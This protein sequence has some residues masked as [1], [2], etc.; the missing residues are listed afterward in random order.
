[1]D[2]RHFGRRLVTA[3]R[4]FRNCS[5][6]VE[7]SVRSRLH[8]YMNFWVEEFCNLSS[9]LHSICNS[10]LIWLCH[11]FSSVLDS[12]IVKPWGSLPFPPQYYKMWSGK[13]I[14]PS[15][16][17]N[18]LAASTASTGTPTEGQQRLCTS[19]AT[20]VR[21]I[22]EG[23]GVC[24]PA[25]VVSINIGRPGTPPRGRI[26]RSAFQMDNGGGTAGAKDSGD[27]GDVKT[28]AG[29]N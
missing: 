10:S 18:K 17:P 25:T 20:T 11:S 5:P 6:L 16:P 7:G 15:P 23:S 2:R 28:S 12:S 1:M 4:Y 3:K 14:P 29:K 8:Q 26:C 13:V 21:V 19:T 27:N 24:R 22:G 9:C